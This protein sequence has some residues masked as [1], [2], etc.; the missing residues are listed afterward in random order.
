MPEERN[1]E[2]E[3]F[4]RSLTATFRAD[5]D[6]DRVVEMSVSSEEPVDRWFGTEIL[7]HD[8]EHIDLRFFGGGS[9]PLLMDHNHREQVGVVESAHIDGV[10]RKVRARVRFSKRQ[11]AQ[12]VLQDVKDG[13]RT[14][15][16][17]GYRIHKT[18]TNEDT[19]EVRVVKWSPYEVSV[20][21]VPADTTVGVG[22][23]QDTAPAN[24]KMEAQMPDNTNAVQ[25][26]DTSTRTV[27]TQTGP[28]EVRFTES[29][30]D[31]RV[32]ERIETRNREVSE[33][34]ALGAMHNMSD[35]ARTH[36]AEGRSLAEFTGHVRENIPEDR[37]L[38]NE[39][40]GLNDEETRSFSVFRL[41]RATSR[42]A[43]RADVEAAR[44]EIDAV[45][46][47]A[48]ASESSRSE[49]HTLPAEVMRSFITAEMSREMGV[50]LQGQRTLL[51]GTDTAL[52]PTEHRDQSFIELLRNAAV[53]MRA[54]VRTLPGLS[55]NVDIPRMAT[56]AGATWISA[57][58]G[59]STDGEPTFD[60]VSLAPKDISVSV[61]MSRRMRQQSAPA[62]EAL[63][64]MDIVQSMALGIDIGVL[65][66]SGAAGQPTGVL[67]Q[68]GVNKPTAFAG[69]N[70]TWAEVVA[71]ETAVADDNALM[72]SLA[73]IGRTNMRGAL[74]TT[75]KD[76]GSGLFVMDGNVL[77][78]Y[79]YLA[80]NSITDGNLYFGNWSEVLMGMWGG[81][82][83]VFDDATLAAKIGLYIRAFQTVDVAVRHAVSF[84]Y[85]NDTP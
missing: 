83:L 17:I 18:E 69:V 76:A 78:G 58:H 52:I 51:A 15:I 74:K 55:G 47:A 26:D 84:A 73:Y 75:A 13:I 46:A 37:P 67:N 70:P 49:G 48:D 54:G 71:M 8:S 31:S 61:P 22:R 24:P 62:I 9:A 2:A 72:G 80:T 63:V 60:S 34:A 79:E 44:F 66:G 7:S 30:L 4:H 35:A 1:I 40:I 68:V 32:N 42:G 21:S 82:D 57:E 20:V 3:Q 53:T 16:S 77:N 33:I 12:E 29:E 5:E 23:S 11:L 10:S 19:D 41:A 28:V 38:R 27:Q 65:E 43:S 39:D 81:L 85:N 25:P 56:S 36:I 64:R 59:D 50:P 6:D 45:N 14:N